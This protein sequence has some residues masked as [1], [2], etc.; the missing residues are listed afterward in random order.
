MT[1]IE[2]VQNGYQ[3]LQYKPIKILMSRKKVNDE[4]IPLQRRRTDGSKKN[5]FQN[6]HN[7]LETYPSTI[8]SV[9]GHEL[10]GVVSEVRRNTSS[11]VEISHQNTENDKIDRN[12]ATKWN[13]KINQPS[14][15]S[16]TSLLR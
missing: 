2:F 5:F 10:W 16:N 13:N 15:Y 7:T 1:K 8:H 4:H 11:V 9:G 14:I 6:L 12:F 3:R